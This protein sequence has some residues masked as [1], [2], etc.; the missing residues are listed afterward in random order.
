VKTEVFV[1]RKDDLL[2]S[3]DSKPFEPLNE[4]QVAYVCILDKE[5]DLHLPF[6]I[7]HIDLKHQ[8]GPIV[9]C[10]GNVGEGHTSFPND[11]IE[12]K[13]ALKCTSRNLQTIHRIL[14]A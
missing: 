4:K 10:V 9:F 2:R 14:K 8:D 6:T 13:F 11:L 5:I 3:I 12:K 7:K 1:L